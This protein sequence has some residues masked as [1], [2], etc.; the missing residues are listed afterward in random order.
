MQSSQKE[1]GSGHREVMEVLACQQDCTALVWVVLL[2][3][4]P[5]TCQHLLTQASPQP[6]LQEPCRA[7]HRASQVVQAGKQ[8]PSTQVTGQAGGPAKSVIAMLTGK[9]KH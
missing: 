5:H 9:Q 6:G 8:Q 7:Q 1:C 3:Q 4:G 2:Q